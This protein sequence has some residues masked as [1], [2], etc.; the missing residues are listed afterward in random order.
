[1]F[2][3]PGTQQKCVSWTGSSQ[4]WKEIDKHR[5]RKPLL[6]LFFL[7]FTWSWVLSEGFTQ[8]KLLS[9]W[10][11]FSAR[12]YWTRALSHLFEGLF[13]TEML[14]TEALETLTWS[15]HLSNLKLAPF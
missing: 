12:L 9:S 1:M 8:G 10:V 4:T 7:I 11:G 13:S 14:D 6:S 15:L 5:K 3:S 2:L